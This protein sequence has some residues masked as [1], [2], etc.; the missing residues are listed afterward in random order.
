MR[1]KYNKLRPTMQGGHL[2]SK[3]LKMES[4][5]KQVSKRGGL[6][7]NGH[8]GVKPLKCVSKTKEMGL[9]CSS[10]MPR[11]LSKIHSSRT[12]SGSKQLGVFENSN[13]ATFPC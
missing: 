13:V 1:R 4:E 12:T 6:I 9:L 11:I 7:G 3:C 2:G 5:D 8:Q 10:S